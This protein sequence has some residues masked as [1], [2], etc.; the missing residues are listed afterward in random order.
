M[1]ALT[2]QQRHLML[3]ILMSI[4]IIS[5]RWCGQVRPLPRRGRSA[6][7]TSCSRS[8]DRTSELPTR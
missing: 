5:E 7:L 3:A 4:P 8:Y 1:I 2:R 6:T